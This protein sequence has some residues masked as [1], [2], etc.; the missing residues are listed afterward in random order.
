MHEIYFKDKNKKV[1]ELT[2]GELEDFIYAVI[3]FI[4]Q[5]RQ[6]INNFITVPNQLNPYYKQNEVY[7]GSTIDNDIKM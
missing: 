5:Q 2:L 4:L 3:N 7:C 1:S 6:T